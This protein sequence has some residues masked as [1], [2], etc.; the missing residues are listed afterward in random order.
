L[1]GSFAY[2][3]VALVAKP[4]ESNA[5]ELRGM[6]LHE[7]PSLMNR[8]AL[9]VTIELTAEGGN[10]ETP[11][12]VATVDLVTVHLES[13]GALSTRRAQL[14]NIFETVIPP[15]EINTPSN[16]QE[17]ATKRARI[18]ILLGDMNFDDGAPEEE[19]VYR[20]GMLDVWPMLTAARRDTGAAECKE[21]LAVEG[22]TMPIDDY[23]RRP[24][25]IDRIFTSSAH[26][27]ASLSL[28]PSHI[29]KIGTR[30]FDVPY[31]SSVPHNEIQDEELYRR[32]EG[33]R[34]DIFQTSQ[35]E[36]AKCRDS[37][38][39]RSSEDRVSSSE[40]PKQERPSD[41]FGLVCDFAWG[42]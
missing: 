28:H 23:I 22:F 8:A 6:E 3:V 14:R 13:L 17:A 19:D 33:R 38:M 31:E 15:K 40:G 34:E 12:K 21:E 9:R 20:A 25:R 2:G 11:P 39:G 5:L 7:L 29:R 16:L 10:A 30:L 41:H 35:Q 1:R 26:D 4:S 18:Q 32:E 36:H 27:D 42:P 37:P 24:T